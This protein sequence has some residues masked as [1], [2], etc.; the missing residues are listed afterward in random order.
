VQVSG[1]AR[2][3]TDDSIIW[4]MRF[5]CRVTQAT[6]THSEHVILTAFPTTTNVTRTRFNVTFTITLPVLFVWLLFIDLNLPLS[7]HY[8]TSFAIDQ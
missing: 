5:A 7:V 1:T 2:Q 4:L 6:D 3:A 8:D